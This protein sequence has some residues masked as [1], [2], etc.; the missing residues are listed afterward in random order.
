MALFIVIKNI[1]YTGVLLWL[2]LAHIAH[3]HGTNLSAYRNFWYPIYHGQSLSYC[4]LD[5]SRCG[6]DIATHYCKLMGYKHSV[7]YVIEHNVKVVNYFSDYPRSSHFVNLNASCKG[8]RCNGFKLIQ[9][10]NTIQ[11]NLTHAHYSLRHFSP[12]R[13]NNHLIDWCYD[14]QSGCGKIAANSFCRRMG[15][16]HSIN[17]RP[18]KNIGAS[19]A[20]GNQKLCFGK[21]CRGFAVIDCLR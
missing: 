3:A 5:G 10:T 11:Q 19:K 7:K 12:P 2:V 21:S 14:G 17:Y 9:C 20:I 16:N 18:A 13:F 8:W 15:Y 4:S 6:L 1:N